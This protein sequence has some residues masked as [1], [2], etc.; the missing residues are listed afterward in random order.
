MVE[1]ILIHSLFITGLCSFLCPLSVS[2]I[3]SDREDT[4][5]MSDLMCRVLFLSVFSASR[6]GVYFCDTSKTTDAL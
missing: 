5:V 4:T 3:V 2:D 6:E 1:G